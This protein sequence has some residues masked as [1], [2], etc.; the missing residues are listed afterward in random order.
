M[1]HVKRVNPRTF[2]FEDAV[3]AAECDANIFK[4]DALNHYI[5]GPRYRNVLAV[6]ASSIVDPLKRMDEIIE[7][8]KL[9]R[10]YMEAWARV[11]WS[12]VLTPGM[13]LYLLYD[14]DRVIGISQWEYPQYMVP[15]LER[16]LG[17]TGILWWVY[18]T[19]MN[20]KIWVIDTVTFW[21]SEH[22]LL[23]ERFEHYH[24]KVSKLAFGEAKSIKQLE[25]MDYQAIEQAQFS[26]DLCV[27]LHAFGIHPDYRGKGMASKLLSESIASIPNQPITIKGRSYSQRMGMTASPMGVP[28]YE[29]HG[30]V[31]QASID[32]PELSET[33]AKYMVMIR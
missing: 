13:D 12:N 30:F 4:D 32:V 33:G 10:R 22:P 7:Q 8:A 28:V 20:F 15:Q 26:E 23:N 2:T 17:R 5:S 29:K 21:K 31:S 18:K 1:I 25:T 19:Y 14:D 6:G 3:K 11:Y 27:T 9:C 16:D 24:T